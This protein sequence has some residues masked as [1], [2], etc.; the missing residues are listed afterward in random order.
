MIK[1]LLQRNKDLDKKYQINEEAIS[2]AKNSL[3][4]LYKH[5]IPRLFRSDEVIEVWIDWNK[6]SYE[7]KHYKQ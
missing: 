7:I 1:E 4:L 2:K 6:Q 3:Q 5:I